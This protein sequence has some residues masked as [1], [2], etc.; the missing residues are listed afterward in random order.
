MIALISPKDT[1]LIAGDIVASSCGAVDL[2][3]V[4]AGIEHSLCLFGC[5]CGSIRYTRPSDDSVPQAGA[6][7]EHS[8]ADHGAHVDEV[9]HG[10]VRTVEARQIA[11]RGDARF[12]RLYCVCL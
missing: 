10:E 11:H 12:Q 8:W 2:H 9:T 4:G 6:R 3:P 1:S 7:H 5:L